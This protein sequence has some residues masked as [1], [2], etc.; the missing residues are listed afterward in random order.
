MRFTVI[1]CVALVLC[2]IGFGCTQG[3]LTPSGLKDSV[4]AARA[5][6]IATAAEI[7]AGKAPI[8]KA[9]QALDRIGG[10]SDYKLKDGSPAAYENGLLAPITHWFRGTKPPGGA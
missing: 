5:D 8:E 7:R 6:A 4:Y 9:L 2:M 3:Q 1:L 10:T